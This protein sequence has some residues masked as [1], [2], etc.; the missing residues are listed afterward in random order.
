VL[1]VATHGTADEPDL[2]GLDPRKRALLVSEHN[3]THWIYDRAATTESLLDEVLEVAG[4]SRPESARLYS[5]GLATLENRILIS[6]EPREQKQAPT[7]AIR[8]P[9]VAGTFYPQDADELNKMVEGFFSQQEVP[10]QAWPAAMVP[11]AGLVYSGRVA[12]AVWEQLKLPETI[13]ILCPK[14]TRNGA[15]WAVAPQAAW[16]IPGA[17]LQA[18][19]ELS[20]RL[21]DRIAGLELDHEAHRQEHA[22]EVELPFVAKLAPQARLVGIAVGACSFRQSQ[23]IAAGLADVLRSLEPRPL[24]IISSDMNHFADDAENRRRDELALRAMEQLDPEQLYQTVTAHQISMCGLMPAVIVMETL[25]QSGG[26]RTCKRVA[27]ATSGDVTGDRSRV[28][29]Y[30]GMLLS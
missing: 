21:A 16:S 5:L 6:G 20:R 23:E 7:P 27:Y 22:I 19:Q 8:P 4:V 13:I 28:V 1:D 10:R 30:A 12:A 26:L 11:H 18:D 3:Q 2:R 9:A 25:R 14:H 15:N 17:T 29:G 24:L